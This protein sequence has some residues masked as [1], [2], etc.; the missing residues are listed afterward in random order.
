[1]NMMTTD[2]IVMTPTV[3]TGTITTTALPSTGTG[4]TFSTGYDFCN[5][6]HNDKQEDGSKQKRD[7]HKTVKIV[8]VEE[9][10]PG[11]VIRCTF[12]DGD[13]QK[14][15]CC[16]E[17]SYTLEAGISICITKHLL[18]GTPQYNKAIRQGIDCYNQRLKEEEEKKQREE[19]KK[20]RKK[21]FEAYKKRRDEKRRQQYIQDQVEIFSKALRNAGKDKL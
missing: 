13:I 18:G 17:D 6:P 20:R 14:A 21:K 16:D 4:I 2:S 1:M 15:V 3:T 5:H 11:K 9:I 10:V 19:Q 7:K 12:S 8:K